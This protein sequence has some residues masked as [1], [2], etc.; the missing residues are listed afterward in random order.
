MISL[1]SEQIQSHSLRSRPPGLPVQNQ[2]GRQWGGACGQRRGTSR[3]KRTSWWGWTG[4]KGEAGE[5][6]ARWNE[7]VGKTG[8]ETSTRWEHVR[9]R[10][11]KELRWDQVRNSPPNKAWCTWRRTHVRRRKTSCGEQTAVSI[12]LETACK[13]SGYT[14]RFKHFL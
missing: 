3:C 10:M 8:R 6:R 5:L 2:P 12:L 9:T 7:T 4:S 11:G 1:I 13:Y 14:T